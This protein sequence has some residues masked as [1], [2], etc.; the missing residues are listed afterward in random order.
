MA[1][2]RLVV[3]VVDKIIAGR[4]VCLTPLPMRKEEDF[5]EKNLFGKQDFCKGNLCMVGL[6]EQRI[7][8]RKQAEIKQSRSYRRKF[9][10]TTSHTF[11]VSLTVIPP[12]IG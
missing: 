9:I 12:S 4:K 3:V 7:R 8:K 6:I 11:Y 1:F 2:V 10:I 5:T